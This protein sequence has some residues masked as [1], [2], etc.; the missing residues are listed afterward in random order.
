MLNNI[1]LV[2]VTC[3]RDLGIQM[4]QSHSVDL[5]ITQTCN[6]YVIIEDS[7]T[8]LES[9]HDMLSP[10]YTRHHLHLIPGNSLLPPS[11]Y[12]NDSYKKHG[13]HRSAV[14][15]LLAAKH[16]QSEKYLILDSKNFFVHP[17]S[18]DDW[19]LQDGNGIMY[20][21]EI[22]GWH[23]VEDFC[24]K[25]NITWPEKVYMSATPFMVKTDIVKEIIKYDILPLFFDKESTW[26]SEIF[27]YSIFTQYFGNPLTQNQVPN[28]TFWKSERAITKETLLDV[29]AWPNMRSFG[30]HRDVLKVGTDL[31]ALIDFLVEIGFDKS[32]I[33]QAI[34]LYEKYAIEKSR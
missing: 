24:L 5:M 27:L 19:P 4:L 18:L 17:Q 9:W 10:Y 28:V 33:N 2:T 16:I 8:S 34:K 29:H 12:I 14:L 7:K 6:H 23:E 20:D 30:L 31:S 26:S 11:S 1:D 15:K 22:L 21:N 3:T 25:N 13:W 32:K